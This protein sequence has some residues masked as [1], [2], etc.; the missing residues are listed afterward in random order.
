MQARILS[1]SQST[2]G[3]RLARLSITGLL[4]ASLAFAQ[5]VSFP[6]PNYFRQVFEQSHAQIDLREPSKLKDFLVDGKLELSLKQFLELVMANNT[7]IQVTFLSLDIPRNNITA[8]FGLWDPLA[9]ASFSST[10]TTSVPTNP[11]TNQNAS[12]G[13]SSKS[14]S[15]PLSLTYAQA[16][17]TGTSYTVSFGGSKNSFS[18]SFSS[19]NPSI[20]SNMS[21]AVS[22]N[23]LRNRT[24]FM[25]R[26]PVMQAQSTFKRAELN[27]RAQLLTW[28]NTAEKTYWAVVSA[29][30]NVRVQE[31]ARETS[32]ANLDF[33][34][35]QLDLGAVSPLDIYNP[36]G[37][38]ASADLALSQA[39]FALEQAEDALRHQIGVDLD[40]DLARTPIELTEPVDVSTTGMDLD[41]E[42]EVQKAIANN[43]N[44][45]AAIQS[46]DVDDLGIQG[47]NVGLLP[48][49]TFTAS[50]SN[51]GQ[52]GIYSSSGSSL[53]G[54]GAAIIVPGGLGDALSQMFGLNNPTYMGRLSLTLPIRSRTASMNLANALVTKKTDAL[55]LR[56]MQ[57]NTRLNVLTALSTLNGS[58]ESL[59]LAKIQEDLQH[60]NY[61]AE[62]EKYT[63]GTDNNQNVVI[64]LQSWVVAQ[65][66][67]VSAQ[68]N[69]RTS[70][71]N[72]YTQTGELLDERGIIVK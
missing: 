61:D 72:L 57:Q 27:L 65:S 55:N 3:R 28:V 69:L 53:L 71:L 33:V 63:L 46:L 58:I 31:K 54:G 40:P 22:Q 59:R 41:P 13:A 51:A 44:V 23:L 17:D 6:R 36:Q 11:A 49:L 45:K 47:A 60:K 43:P 62:M 21:F 66:S 50:Y 8:A 30:E 38:L 64:A 32:K 14:L 2:A 18:N 19:Y 20:S 26:I 12:F 24:R 39:K 70:V 56:N 15:Q 4:V 35:K 16:L 42:H 68:V 29:R 25:N 9:N 37:Q 34:Q 1:S 52:G 48:Q 10:R 5:T 67:V 7:D